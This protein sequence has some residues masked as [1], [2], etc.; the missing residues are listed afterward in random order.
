MG[1]WSRSTAQEESTYTTP[2]EIESVTRQQFPEAYSVYRSYCRRASKPQE[3]LGTALLIAPQ[4]DDYSEAEQQKAESEGLASSVLI[5]KRRWIACLFTSLGYGRP[6][7]ANDNPGKDSKERILRYTRNAL[8]Y[9]RVLLEEFGPSNFNEDTN[10]QTD[11]DKPGD[12]WCCKFNSGAFGVDWKETEAI[13]DQ[14]FWTFERPW[15]VV[16]KVDKAKRA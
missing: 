5:E 14:E 13:V 7:I 15:T 9:L 12:I 1:I 8:E 3:L 2:N 4:P 11:D 16:E 6:S 10:W